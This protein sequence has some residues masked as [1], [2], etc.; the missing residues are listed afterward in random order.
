MRR[1]VAGA[2]RVDV[3]P[4]HQQHV[5]EHLGLGAPSGRGRDAHSCRFTPR[6]LIGRAVDG[7]HAVGD[8]HRAEADPQPDPLA[9]RWPACPRRASGSRP[10]RAAPSRSRSVLVAAGT[11]TA[12]FRRRSAGPSPVDV[13]PQR[14]GDR[15]RGR[16]RRARRSRGCRRPGGDSSVTSRKMP[17]QPPHVLV[18]QVAAGRPL[19]HPHR[20]HVAARCRRAS[21]DVELGRQPLPLARP[22]LGAVEPDPRS[23]SRR[24]RSA[25]PRGR[26]RPGP[27]GSV[28]GRAGSRR[29]GSRPAR[30]AG[31]PGTGSGRSCTR[32]R[33]KAAATA[34]AR[35]PRWCPRPSRRRRPPA[36][37][38]DRRQSARRRIGSAR[39]RSGS[40]AE[41]RSAARSARRRAPVVGE[42]LLEPR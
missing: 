30:T 34:S 31:R 23:T 3:V 22:S 39:C 20:E 11:S 24:R 38:V 1:V 16:S 17:G 5:G 19:V 29:S 35:G 12:E 26:R 4:L 37:S 42:V 21:V 7:E 40:A 18:L 6:S 28:E 9:R 33:R 25:A 13:D 36:D 32:G 41:R 14:A 27:A 15:C 8:R 2:D 10:T